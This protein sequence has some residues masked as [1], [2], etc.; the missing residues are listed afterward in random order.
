MRH[1]GFALLAALAVP[2]AGCA[3]PRAIPAVPGA[4]ELAVDIAS[5]AGGPITFAFRTAR[6]VAALHFADDLGGYRR[7]EWMPVEPGFRWVVEPADPAL[8]TI[9]GERIERIDGA[10]FA[11]VSFTVDP[12]YRSLPKN[13]AP[14]SPFSD[15]GLLIYSGHLHACTAFPCSGAG[16]I[17]IGVEAPDRQVRADGRT[18]P[19]GALF[20]SAREGTNIYIGNRAPL[21]VGGF[22]DAILDPALPDAVRA[23]LATSLPAATGYFARQYGPL[24]FTP[25]LFVSVDPRRQ[26]DGTIS[27]QGGT[28]PG[29]IFMHFDGADEGRRFAEG[30]EWLDWFFAHEVA[31][32][33]QR[34]RT[35]NRSGDDA[36]AWMHEG[37]ADAMAALVMTDRGGAAYVRRRVASAVSSCDEALSA[38]PLTSATARGAFDAH[39]ACG[40]IAHI[41]LDTA[42]RAQGSDLDSFNRMFFARVRD[43]APWSQATWFAAARDAGAGP[44]VLAALDALV[45]PDAAAGR[46]ALS[47]LSAGLTG[48]GDAPP[49]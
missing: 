48:S 2:L 16:P 12:R 37:G 24:S 22:A 17:T 47:G 1:F 6:P 41:A 21:S 31:H 46:A 7:R 8:G 3:T 26:P 36:Q 14:F 11:R 38:G 27:T 5:P 4:P 29:Q 15:G 43:G 35:G 42:L 45:G 30:T 13:Y 44:A 39:Y 32:M 23:G 19:G 40:L 25:T 34:D 9:Q 28:L 18:A 33:V 49:R 20:A 10:S